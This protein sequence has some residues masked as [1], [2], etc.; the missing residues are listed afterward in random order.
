MKLQVL[1]GSFGKVLAAIA[2][3]F[4]ISS[5]APVQ[6]QQG[7]W[8]SD[9]CFYAVQP[10]YAQMVRQGCQHLVNGQQRYYDLRS[11]RW[12]VM[13]TQGW[14]DL[15]ALRANTVARYNAAVQQYR[16][17]QAAAAGRA[18]ASNPNFPA[19]YGG[20]IVGGDPNYNTKTVTL[21]PLQ[22]TMRCYMCL[23]NNV[24]YADQQ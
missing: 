16:N 12:S 11:G 2:I 17:A 20:G 10:G 5:A 15:E 9:G 4:M 21:G 18:A 19:S 24:V 7:Q 1:N 22:P 3:A 6:A 13:T 23:P 8:Y 14:V